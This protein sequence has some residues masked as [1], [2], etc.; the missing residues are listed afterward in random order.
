MQQKLV[1]V[2]AGTLATRI[3]ASR[4]LDRTELMLMFVISEKTEL[5]INVS[6]TEGPGVALWLRRCATS[7]AVP[8]SIFGGVP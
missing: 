5:I 3:P 4:Y 1:S 7:R 6:S 2:A 8:G